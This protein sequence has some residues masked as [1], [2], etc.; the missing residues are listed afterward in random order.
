MKLKKMIRILIKSRKITLFFVFLVI[1]AGAL[2]YIALPKQESPDF[3]VPYAMVTTLY[4]GAPQ[5]DVDAYVTVPVTETVMGI[6]GYE[7]S[8]SYSYNNMSLVVLE[9]RFSA[10]REESFRQL[11]EDLAELQSSLPE[12]CGQISVNTNITD[13]AG[14]LISLS[15]DKLT[16][17]QVVEQAKFIQSRLSA[18]EGFQ[19]FQIIGKL[20]TVISVDVNEAKMKAANLTLNKIL[21]LIG[22]GNLDLPLGNVVGDGGQKTVDYTGGFADADDVAA[23]EI[24]YSAQMNR[25]IRLGDIA[26]VTAKTSQ[27]NTYY[28]H[29][30][31]QAVILAG[32]FTDGINVLPL[33]SEIQNELDALADELPESLE[34]SLIIS[35]PQEISDSLENFLKN[36]LVAVCLVILVV[37]FGM[38]IKNAVVVSVSLPLSVLMA[39]LAMYFLGIKIQQ[40]SVAALVLSLGMLVD[41]SI[42]VSDSIQNYLDAGEKRMDACV[43]GVKSV[44]LPI[45]TSTLTTIAAFAPFIFLNS[46]AGDYIKSLPQIVCIALAASYISAIFIIPVLGYIFFKPRDNAARESKKQVFEK[47]LRAAMRHRLAV[48][49]VVLVLLAGSGYLAVNLD[50]IFFPAS[51][52]NILY[53]DVRNNTSNDLSSTQEIMDALSEAVGGEPG[54]T[55]YTAAVGGGLPRFNRIMYIYTQTPDIGQLMM[56]V[57]LKAAGFKTNGDFK[58]YLQGKIDAL[59]LDAKITVKELMYAFPMDEDV[60][61]KI[62]GGDLDELKSVEGDVYALLIGTDGLVNENRSN[63]EY[64]GSYALEIDGEAALKNGIIPAEA[65]NEISIAMLG[66][67]AAYIMDGE[68]KTSIMVTGGTP[69]VND[70]NA[71]ALQNSGGGYVDAGEIISLIETQALSSIPRIEGDYAMAVTADFDL[72]FDK[73]ETLK[74]VK[75]QIKTLVPDGV[76]IDYDGEDEIIKENFGQVG[77]LGLVALAIVFVVLLLQ[78]K[79][80]RIPLIIFITIP[81]SVIGSVTGL[82]ITGLP[83]SFTA[84]LGV[85][86]LLGI[87]VNNAIILLDT[88]NKDTKEGMELQAACVGASMRRLRPILL[89]SVTTVIGLIPLAVGHSQLF[90]PMAVALMSGLLVSALLTLVVLP[91]FVSFA[92]RH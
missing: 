67:E 92:G 56:R 3:S 60:K 28:T 34:V 44:A 84:L 41:N 48:I 39:F 38:G 40:I 66:R 5:N 22:A 14:V 87:V 10:D 6:D 1:A 50:T 29:N 76:R 52:K 32:Y 25:I 27:R 69:S 21:A 47:F 89:S 30:G 4:P 73:N 70:I 26:E 23:L 83:L 64:Q 72:D 85:V 62:L 9:L 80:F 46:V 88:I 86:S 91:V 77:V 78:F 16:N 20:D 45:L 19:R 63:S 33:K 82:Y 57:D 81:L 35:Q 36:L 71:I 13:T 68:Y 42:V 51:D 61:I 58:L 75:E 24:G 17:D 74:T 43:H 37:L 53:I 11:K 8:F 90:R 31:K 7:T 2:A 54:V 55:E 65:L 49:A 12:D 18:I 59:G 79:S 15:S